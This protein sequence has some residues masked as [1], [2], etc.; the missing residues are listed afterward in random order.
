[1]LFQQPHEE[2]A[3]AVATLQVWTLRLSEVVSLPYVAQLVSDGAGI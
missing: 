1:M 3:V 2:Y